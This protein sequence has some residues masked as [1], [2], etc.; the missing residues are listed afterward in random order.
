MVGAS[1][2]LREA[3]SVPLP[4]SIRELGMARVRDGVG[5]NLRKH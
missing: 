1:I 5:T 3:A 4:E 2:G